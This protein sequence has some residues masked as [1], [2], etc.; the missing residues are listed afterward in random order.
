MQQV[1]TAKA[2]AT[3]RGFSSQVIR[4]SEHGRASL[5]DIAWNSEGAWR[6]VT[7]DEGRNVDTGWAAY[8]TPLG[9]TDGQRPTNSADADF[10][11]KSISKILPIMFITHGNA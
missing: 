1:G 9:P 11:V 10:L 7:V 2:A 5:R 6:S 8:L 4:I 3:F